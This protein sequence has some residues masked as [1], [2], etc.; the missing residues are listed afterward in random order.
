MNLGQ[1][2][3]L[4]FFWLIPAL[5]VF[6][7]WAF[8]KRKQLMDRFASQAVLAR[9]LQGYSPVRRGVKAGFIVLAI[10]LGIAALC[11]PRWGYHWEEVRSRG[12]D[13]YVA[14]DLSRSMRAQ[15]VAPSRLDRA[16]RKIADLLN[17]VEGDRV[18]LIGFA[19]TA[20]IQCPLTLDYDALRSLLD[21]MDTDSISVPG[22]SLDAPVEK[23]VESLEAAGNKDRRTAALVVFSDGEDHDGHLDEAIKRA[24]AAGL[25]VY[26]VGVGRESGGAPIPSDDG[27]GFKKNAAGELILT[28]LEEKALKQLSLDTGGSYVRSVPGDEDLSRIYQD[29]RRQISEQESAGGRRKKYEER[30]QWPLLLAILCLL[31]EGALREGEPEKRAPRVWRLPKITLPKRR[32]RTAATTVFLLALGAFSRP[33]QA[34]WFDS[35]ARLG[36]KSYADGKYEEALDHFLKAQVDAPRD[37]KLQYNLANTY[38]KLQR[39]DD[40]ERAYQSALE[41]K[42]KD[43]QARSEY[44][45]GN[46][47]FRQGKLDDAIT[48]YEK[49]LQQN[50]KDE[51][52]QYNLALAKKKKEEPPPPK[53]NQDSKKDQKKE[54]SKENQNQ[55]QN[56]SAKNES[57]PNEKKNPS[58]PPKSS[59]NPSPDKTG[60]GQ[61]QAEKNKENSPPPSGSQEKDGKSGAG[62]LSQ[63]NKP[64]PAKGQKPDEAN[65][66]KEGAK[67]GAEAEPPPGA[68]SKKEADMW[69]S[70]V[71]EGKRKEGAARGGG[72]KGN[73]NAGG[74]DW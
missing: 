73:R 10:A 27:G 21:A 74:K 32:R 72:G 1:P 37:A 8:R 12:V 25:K 18:G 24:K 58:D 17:L 13:I 33:A 42:A 4:I 6:F 65:G 56:D 67:A 44:N 49:A 48:H 34:G 45:L 2:H 16:K 15:D 26:A 14:L 36:E 9:L 41:S 71:R 69:L 53:Q 46:T 55:S 60:Q 19:G 68:M 30:F 22:T 51:D 7:V 20:F 3:N 11:Q 38:Y 40:A 66:Q 52:S 31:V 23:A 50:P 70:R 35:E 43:L 47:A 62:G 61:S 28:R 39:F 63:G 64:E 5:V 57:S 29:I 54:D 59:S